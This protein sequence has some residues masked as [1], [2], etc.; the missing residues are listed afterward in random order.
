VGKKIIN[1]LDVGS[2]RIV[3]AQGTLDTETGSVVLN[4]T[5]TMRTQ[6]IH[7]SRIV[8]RQEFERS[9]LRAADSLEKKTKRKYQDIFVNFSSSGTRSQFVSVKKEQKSTITTKNIVALS[10][11]IVDQTRHGYQVL[12]IIPL[13]YSLDNYDG[14]RDPR[15]MR[16]QNISGH[17]H[18]IIAPKK[19]IDLLTQALYDCHI[20]VEAFVATPF[21]SG[22]ACS[23]QDERN[24]GVLTIDIGEGF[25]HISAFYEGQCIHV[26]SLPIGGKHISHDISYILGCSIETAEKIKRLHGS[27]LAQ[28]K[29]AHTVIDVPLASSLAKEDA[30]AQVPIPHLVKI[31]RAR[32]EEILKNVKQHLAKNHLNAQP[33]HRAILTG[34][35]AH[36]P[37]IKDLA[38]SVLQ[39]PVR[40]GVSSN[41]QSS[42]NASDMLNLTTACG[43]MHIK[44][45]ELK[46]SHTILSQKKSFFA[47]F[48]K[49]LQR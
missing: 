10:E 27:A 25:T 5:V 35:V 39:I 33:L 22:L 38:S 24:I 36:T 2:L 18:T 49:K 11:S 48:K 28:S 13:S 8:D 37:R 16:C 31:M 42:Y 4:E 30:I 44:A 32:I 26:A 19:E 47:Q 21:A 6:G 14:V 20:N 9:I 23:V 3:C 41:I 12:H 7:R 17:F 34:G 40:I 15:G 45:R 1:V 46:Q 29:Q 43:L